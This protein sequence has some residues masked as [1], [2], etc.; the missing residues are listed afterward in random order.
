MNAVLKLVGLRLQVVAEF[1]SLFRGPSFEFW[2]TTSTIFPKLGHSNRMTENFRLHLLGTPFWKHSLNHTGLYSGHHTRHETWATLEKLL[3]FGNTMNLDI[4]WNI[5]LLDPH[6]TSYLFITF[7]TFLKYIW[8]QSWEGF[9]NILEI[10]LTLILESSKFVWRWGQPY[11]SRPYVD[12]CTLDYGMIWWW[13][14]S[15]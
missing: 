7:I 14:V 1:V 12:Y 6:G 9:G 8:L 5:T 13:A 10:T 4:G 3:G 15:L 2:L 11:A